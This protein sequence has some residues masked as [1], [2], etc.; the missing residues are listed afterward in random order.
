MKRKFYS[1]QKIILSTCCGLYINSILFQSPKYNSY[2]NSKK[3]M[4]FNSLKFFQQH[5][6]G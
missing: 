5:P 4:T 3:E 1:Y 2:S 6:T